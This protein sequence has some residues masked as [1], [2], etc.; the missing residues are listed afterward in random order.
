MGKREVRLLNNDRIHKMVQEIIEVIKLSS[1]R[2]YELDRENSENRH[3]FQRYHEEIDRQ[4]GE[5][6]SELRV[7][8]GRF[9]NLEGDLQ[10]W[11]NEARNAEIMAQAA[12]HRYREAREQEMVATVRTQF[13]ENWLAEAMR[14][15]AVEFKDI[16]GDDAR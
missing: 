14:T 13:L 11:Q 4:D 10:H 2:L 7:M 12:V 15:I 3:R 9:E 5:R 1:E 8:V 16:V 6:L